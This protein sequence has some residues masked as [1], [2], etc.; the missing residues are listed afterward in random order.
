[1]QR[2]NEKTLEPGKKRSHRRNRAGVC[3]DCGAVS[4][5]AIR[6]KRF[7][8]DW[9]CPKCRSAIEWIEQIVD[10]CKRELRPGDNFICSECTAV[11]M[12]TPDN[13]LRLMTEVELLG[14]RPASQKIIREAQAR[15]KRG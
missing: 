8:G 11:S 13:R 12:L 5:Q 4:H 3:L 1:M 14:R 15:I 6:G 9:T 7:I 2:C 10:Q